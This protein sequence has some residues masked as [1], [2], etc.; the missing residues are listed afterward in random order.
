MS[1]DLFRGRLVRLTGENPE[2][3]AKASVLWD[4]NSEFR[5]LLDDDPAILWSKDKI[6]EWIEKDIEGQEGE[7]FFALRTVEDNHLI[8]FVSLFEFDWSNGDCLV[9]IGLGDREYWGR[10]YGSEAMNL[11]LRYAFDELNLYR[12]SLVVFEYNLR[13]IRAYEK[14]GFKVEGRTRQRL[15]REG[16]RWDL[17]YMSL[18]RDEWRA[19]QPH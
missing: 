13:A 15:L 11:I 1:P 5:R 17:V 14:V 7:F 3:L 9:G 2:T 8:G 18:L 16:R 19:S 6:R 4:R 10:G 12:V